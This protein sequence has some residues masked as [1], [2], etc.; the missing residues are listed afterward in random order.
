[1]STPKRKR[2]ALSSPLAPPAAAEAAAAPN[3]PAATGRKKNA[4]VY[5]SP[6]DYTRASL[7]MQLWG[8]REGY[9]GLSDMGARLIMAE[10]ERIEREHNDGQRLDE[11]NPLDHI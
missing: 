10:V 9:R 5:L 1:M 11:H 6:A 3:R 8:R 7:A 4:S 2:S